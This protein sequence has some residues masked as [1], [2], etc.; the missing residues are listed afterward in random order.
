[1]NSF[2]ILFLVALAAKVC[3]LPF[4]GVRHLRLV[5]SRCDA[6]PE[7]FA[8]QIPLVAHRK[9]A[10]YTAARTSFGPV[11]LDWNALLVLA[12]T[13]GGGLAALDRMWLRA[14]F[15]PLAHGVAVLLSALVLMSL[16]ELPGTLYRT[17][18]IEQR[19]GFNRMTP[20]L[21]AIDLL[22]E[23]LL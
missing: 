19:F 22:K 12:W 11:E 2:T 14:D 4:L 3:V 13:L 15:G 18:V 7:A 20:R 17:F 8:A 5:R 9:A 6:L 10:D 21:F 1:L 23:A 16:L